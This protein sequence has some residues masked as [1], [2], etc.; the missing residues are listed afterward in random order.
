MLDAFLKPGDWFARKR[1]GFGAGLP[2]AWQGWV[3]YALYLAI[4]LGC[5][6]WR[7]DAQPLDARAALVAMIGAT[8][9]LF[10]IV[11][12]RTQPKE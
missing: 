5:S 11:S 3:V 4:M 2:I 9:L 1:F 8:G 10:L 12:R 7:H 6:H